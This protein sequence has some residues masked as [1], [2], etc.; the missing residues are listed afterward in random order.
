MNIMENTELIVNNNPKSSFSESIKTIRT[1][2]QFSLVN[3][4][5][6]TILLTSPEPGD[7]KS[8]ISANLAVA[9]A[10]ENKR[11]LL[12]DSDLRKGRQYKVFKV[13][14][15]RSKGYSN[16]ILSDKSDVTINSFIIE[17][18]IKN[19][20]LLPNGVTPPNPSELL[21]S[22]NNKEL[23]DKLK[24]MFDI[25][26]LDCAP[27]LGLNDTLVMTKYSDVNAVVVTNK[28][29]KV[30][31]LDQVKK[32]FERANAKIDGVILNRLKQKETSYY[33]YYG[34]SE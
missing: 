16:L 20:Y 33:G 32:N 29:T 15:D 25:I 4:R 7:G 21:S 30:E 2:L 8:F 6:K 34:E 10:Q 17:T 13:K 3:S 1:N 26:I 27:V 12:I 31:L 9:F 24:A 11:V 22:T 14:N 23:L 19:L 18:D 5:T 28:K